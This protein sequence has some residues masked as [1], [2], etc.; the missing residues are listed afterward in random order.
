M[1]LVFAVINYKQD[2]SSSKDLDPSILS[3]RN[4]KCSIIFHNLE[5]SNYFTL[6][7]LILFLLGNKDYLAV[8]DNEKMAK[9][10]FGI[11]K[12]EFVLPFQTVILTYINIYI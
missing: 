11:K 4:N 6:A 3:Y 5:N 1:K 12:L 9:G 7:F 8:F 2:T 10:F